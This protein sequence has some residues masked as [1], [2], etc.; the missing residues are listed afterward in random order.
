MRTVLKIGASGFC[1]VMLTGLAWYQQTPDHSQWSANQIERLRM[2]ALT[3]AEAKN[4][5][6]SAAE[7]G[8]LHAQRAMAGMLLSDPDS[9]FWLDGLRYANT[10]A[11]RGD[12]DAFYLLGQAWFNGHANPTHMPDYGRARSWFEMAAEQGHGKAQYWL[13]L[14][15]KSG[16]GIA[17]DPS[18]AAVWLQQAAQQQ[19][20]D[21]M[22]VLGNLYAYGEGVARDAVRARELYQA[23]AAMEH[24]LAAQTLAYALQQGQ[25]GLQPDRM[26][27]EQMLHEVSDH[28]E[29]TRR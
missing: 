5:L 23:A 6:R 24:P 22:F 10:A 21:A 20:A 18:R 17:A 29:E 28:A 13:G 19:D 15:Y 27:A 11:T 3:V 16:Y 1:L 8:N 26:A 25:L 7:Q 12:R 9:N 14:I 2:K 4:E